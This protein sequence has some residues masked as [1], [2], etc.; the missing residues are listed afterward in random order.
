[1][2][3]D[4]LRWK[5]TCGGRQ[6]SVED[7]L[8]WI[9]ACCLLCFAAILVFLRHSGYIQD[10]FRRHPSYIQT[11]M[12]NSYFIMKLR[13]HA[14]CTVCASP[15]HALCT[16]CV[17]LCTPFAWPMHIPFQGPCRPHAC[18]T[19][20][21][22]RACP[23]HS[24]YTLCEHLVHARCM[25]HAQPVQNLYMSCKPLCTPHARPMQAP[26]SPHT[27]PVH[28]PYTPCASP[29]L[30]PSLRWS[31]TILMMATPIQNMV[32]HLER[33]LT[34]LAKDGHQPSSG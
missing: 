24:P 8:C 6:P 11:L 4:Y 2:V 28:A 22:P 19:P 17:L 21:T 33:M 3:E 9:L 14:T 30:Q 12:K 25:P 27:L 29:V 16:L 15:M 5:T 32:S 20:C 10:T 18:P 23:L 26:C 34:K 1:M 7:D 13:T 31:P